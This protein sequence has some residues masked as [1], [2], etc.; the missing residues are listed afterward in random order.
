MDEIVYASIP[1]LDIAKRLL[2]EIGTKF[3]QV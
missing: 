3:N 1:K 2:E